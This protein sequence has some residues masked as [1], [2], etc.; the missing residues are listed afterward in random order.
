MRFAVALLSIA[1]LSLSA[2]KKNPTTPS[3]SEVLQWEKSK[4][5]RVSVVSAKEL[6]P[7]VKKDSTLLVHPDLKGP[8]AIKLHI[9]TAPI[10]IVEDGKSARHT[11]PLAVCAVVDA[12]QDWT[13]EAEC[14]EGPHY[15]LG[16]V[17]GRGTM[18]LPEAMVLHCGLVIHYVDMMKNLTYMVSLQVMG[19]GTFT[20]E[21]VG[22]TVEVK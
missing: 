7:R 17:D 1:L 2:C 10:E 13:V 8:I 22:G 6:E 15:Q 14:N 16:L 9:E 19:D 4:A 3:G 21:M 11:S 12:N 5:T 20:P 18:N